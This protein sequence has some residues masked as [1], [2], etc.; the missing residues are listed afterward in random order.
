MIFTPH[1]SAI[2]EKV[3]SEENAKRTHLVI[4]LS[5]AHAYGFPSPDSDFDLKAIHIVPTRELL[6]LGAEQKPAERLEVIE[7]VEVDYSSNELQHVLKSVLHGNGNYI[8][9]I[10][11]HL[12]LQVDAELQS[13]KP[14]VKACLSKNVYRHYNGFAR[15]QQKEW[16]KTGFKVAKKL[17]YVLR[18]T[19]TG[20]HALSTGEIV[21]DVTKLITD[22][23]ISELIEQK[24]RGEKS[25]LPESLASAW[26][27]RVDGYFQRL[28][29]AMEKSPLPSEPTQSAVAELEQWLLELRRR[30][31]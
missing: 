5:G 27:S 28:E 1:Q 7:G 4:S 14:L 31:F 10:L 25:E 24:R 17:L 30:R 16:E 12:Q 23:E 11:G 22:S 26:R 9:R 20:L 21:T 18:T 13:L 19:M 29:A 2:V 8:E 6:G 3:L 15:Q